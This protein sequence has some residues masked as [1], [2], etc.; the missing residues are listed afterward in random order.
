M[1]ISQRELASYRLP[2]PTP[3]IEGKPGDS[4]GYVG[5]GHGRYGHR[6]AYEAAKGPIPD[7]LE[8][9]HL[10]RN[11][12]CIN[13]DHL[14]A[15]THRENVRRAMVLVTGCAQGHAFTEDNT[16]MLHGK[17]RRCRTCKRGWDREFRARKRAAA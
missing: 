4:R 3:C 11:R 15:V 6:D 13:P 2:M 5:T 7:G 12:A 16:Y 17:Y 1:T 9:D 10:C 8:I 14:E